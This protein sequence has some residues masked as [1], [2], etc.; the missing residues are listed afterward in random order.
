RLWRALGFPDALG[1]RAFTSADGD[2]IRLLTSLVDDGH[3]D[4]DTSIRLTRAVGH[5]MA[6]LADWQVGTLSE[7]IQSIEHA[8]RGTG[9]RLQTGLGV[10]RTVEPAFEELLLYAWRRHLAAAVGRVEAL[11]AEE[12]DLHNL[13]VTVGFADKV[14]FTHLSN[15][16]DGERLADLV[17]GFESACADLVTAG[18]GRVIKTL[19][20]S[21]LFIAG[22]P[23]AGI[24]IA[25][26]VIQ[27][28]GGDE[29]LPDV[30]VGMATGPVVMRLGDVFG[31]SVNLASRLTG[32]ARRNRLICDATTAAAVL[33]IEGYAARSMTERDIRGFGV[34]QPISVRRADRDNT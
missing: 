15:G 30:H 21:V 24:D 8:G 17:E 6:R 3:L 7:Y 28:I 23:R 34:V 13:V 19:G 33:G 20:D 11:G 2:A 27:R 29:N 1:A 14:S 26:D 16:I 4:L 31:R 10:L 5:T 9:S 25:C 12:A 32:V 22:G 18:G